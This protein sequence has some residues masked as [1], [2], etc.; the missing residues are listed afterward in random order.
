MAPPPFDGLDDLP[1]PRRHQVGDRRAGHHEPAG[2][3]P[4]TRSAGGR[5]RARWFRA[6]VLARGESFTAAVLVGIIRGAAPAPPRRPRSG[7]GAASPFT[8]PGDGGGSPPARPVCSPAP[9]GLRLP[10]AGGDSG[11]GR[12]CLWVCGPPAGPGPAPA[13]HRRQ[14]VQAWSRRRLERRRRLRRY[15]DAGWSPGAHESCAAALGSAGGSVPDLPRAQR[16][17]RGPRAT[18]A[19]KTRGAVR[20]RRR[21]FCLPS[22]SLAGGAPAVR[23]RALTQ[24]WICV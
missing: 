6:P 3:S 8:P 18:I 5:R 13:H 14:A 23:R 1:R 12:E 21:I 22:P 15:G 2:G 9:H 7:V 24:R 10:P 16:R 20:R 4:A 19:R 17:A 11:R